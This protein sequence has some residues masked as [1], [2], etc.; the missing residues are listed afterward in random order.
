MLTPEQVNKIHQNTV[1][2]HACVVVKNKEF[3]QCIDYWRSQG[4]VVETVDD[5]LKLLKEEAS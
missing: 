5:F 1:D 3:L 4:K 2:N